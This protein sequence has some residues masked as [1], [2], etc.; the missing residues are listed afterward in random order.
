[1]PRRVSR[2]TVRLLTL[3]TFA[4]SGLTSVSAAAV[5]DVGAT[6]LRVPPNVRAEGMGRAF[7]FLDRGPYAVWGNVGALELRSGVALAGT[8][9]T[10][11]GH[12]DYRH[13]TAAVGVPLGRHPLTLGLS[14]TRA[15]SEGYYLV[16]P[17]VI[18]NGPGDWTDESIG[19]AVA[20]GL[21]ERLS[22]GFG[23]KQLR[24]NE[25]GA[26]DCCSGPFQA[27]AHA[28]DVGLYAT[29]PAGGGS[30]RES[31]WLGGISLQN[32]GPDFTIRAGAGRPYG[33]TGR[34]Q[35]P[36]SLRVAVGGEWG[37]HPTGALASDRVAGPAQEMA[38][39]TVAVAVEKGLASRDE[40]SNYFDEDSRLERQRLFFSG[41]AEARVRDFIALRAGYVYGDTRYD[42]GV[43][44][45]AGLSWGRR[46]G[47]DVAATPG[48]ND[49]TTR[50]SAWLRWPWAGER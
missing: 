9:G 23:Y 5:P 20:C 21:S 16:R 48:G 3:L 26:A 46:L 7:A 29:L 11:G 32:L 41:G 19:A 13:A 17:S 33:R 47:V 43:T 1:M 36:G 40:Y 39:L 2:S 25:G 45:G 49:Y 37:V 42:D 44:A 6:L 30:G 31:R 4:V 8:T 18:N 10:I 14:Y 50:Y 35:L 28:F 24:L 22:L 38:R 27:T 15:S 12:V 34:R